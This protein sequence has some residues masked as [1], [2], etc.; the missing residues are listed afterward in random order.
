MF[1]NL[2]DSRHPSVLIEQLGGT[3][4]Y[5]L[6]SNRRKK[7]KLAAPLQFFTASK[8]SAAPRLRTTALGKPE[9]FNPGFKVTFEVS[10]EPY[11][12]QW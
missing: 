2:F 12:S 7:L 3:P 1:L 4:S 11:N 9:L 5:N 8:G 6:P 10:I